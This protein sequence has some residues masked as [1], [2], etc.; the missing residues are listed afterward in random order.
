[1]HLGVWLLL[2]ILPHLFID[3]RTIQPGFFPGSW[4]TVT[5]IYN[6][7][8]FYFTA[9]YLYPR[10]FNKRNGWLF[11]VWICGLLILSY[12]IKLWFTRQFYPDV[13]LDVWAYRILFFPLAAFLTASIIYKLIIDKIN[14]DKKQKEI[15]AEQ[16]D[17][18]LKFLRSQVSPHFIF[19]VL[20]N[21]VSLARKQSKQLEP[22]L[23]M[24]SDLM[25][26]ML[27]ESDENKVLL[28]NE[29]TYLESYINLQQ[30][31]FSDGLKLDL[32]INVADE[33]L[34]AKI[35]PMLLV[36]F[37]EN[38]YKHG[39]VGDDSHIVIQLNSIRN[40]IVFNVSNT[41]TNDEETKDSNSGIGLQNV[42]SRLALLYPNKHEL[43]I[44]RNG[45][46]FVIHLTIEITK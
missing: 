35:E 20:T 5:N 13:I 31:R 32:N 46:Y 34:R 26:Y 45:R 25:R 36:P 42:R 11:F 40:R 6:V 4:F 30:M 18:K 23:I 44:N 21:L 38:A 43:T 41:Y 7:G 2:F 33:M 9:L 27:Y 12:F 29:I 24:L 17:V 28:Q 3:S 37:V 39:S 8:L 1:M 19:N 14:S 15:I 10:Y 16:L 22:A